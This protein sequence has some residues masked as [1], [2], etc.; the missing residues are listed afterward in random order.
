MLDPSDIRSQ[1][2]SESRGSP[3]ACQSCAEG[4]REV[5]PL[6]SLAG[7][8]AGTAARLPSPL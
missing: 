1:G 2:L 3:T 7:V 4:V 5:S 8:F 6:C